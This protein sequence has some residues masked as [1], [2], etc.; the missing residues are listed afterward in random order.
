MS[1]TSG[2]ITGRN[3][4]VA[5]V[6][7][8]QLWVILFTGGVSGRE[9]PPAKENPPQARENPPAR[10]TPQ[11]GDPPGQGEPP[12][13]GDSPWPGRTPQPGRTPPSWETPPWLGDPCPWPGRTPA[14]SRSKNSTTNQKRVYGVGTDLV[15]T[16]YAH[17]W[18][19][20]LWGHRTRCT[21]LVRSGYGL[22]GGG[23][24]ILV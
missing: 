1:L 20:I 24:K 18:P 7:F 12:W 15:R 6:M 5:K 16:G 10:D 11:L 14:G 3:E 23:M 17:I 2:I 13:L 9:N 4:V 8:L 21:E 22:K 19:G